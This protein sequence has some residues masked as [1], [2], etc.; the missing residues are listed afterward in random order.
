[1]KS[2]VALATTVAAGAGLLMING[3][4]AVAGSSGSAGE[5]ATTTA[6]VAVLSAGQEVPHPK[7]A[8]AGASG[9]FTA[10]LRGTTL[11]WRLTFKQLSG[12][13]SAAHIHMAPAKKAGPVS[14]PL[15]GPC[16][17]PASGTLTLTTQQLAALRSRG[18]YVNVHTAA[19]PG[20]EIRG[21][22]AERVDKSSKMPTQTNGVTTNGA[23]TLPSKSSDN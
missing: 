10:T 5:S 21:Q 8:A 2:S 7:G 23:T 4:T 20:G 17:S 12:P 16:T 22:L 1:M 3:G 11:A 9:Q 18:L 14:A 13:A 6:V 19:N 15:C